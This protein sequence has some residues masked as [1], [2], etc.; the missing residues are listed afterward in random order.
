MSSPSESG[1]E[2]NANYVS[3]FE[4][5]VPCSC[6]RQNLIWIQRACRQHRM[7]N[8][9]LLRL[10]THDA[11]RLKLRCLTCNRRFF[12][13][14]D[15]GQNGRLQR[16]GRYGS[17]CSQRRDCSIDYCDVM[18]LFLSSRS[19]QYDLFNY[20]C[21]SWARDFHREI[22]EK[23]GGSRAID[24]PMN[25]IFAIYNALPDGRSYHRVRFDSEAWGREFSTKCEPHQAS[26]VVCLHHK[27]FPVVLF[28]DC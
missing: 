18:R 14:F 25:N 23:E 21:K 10:A 4:E 1:S 16:F 24:R 26:G 2:P 15:F 5:M 20:N 17:T 6:H 7:F 8:N 3:V 19:G 12:E 11:I 9:Y 28:V 27:R 22:R 13:T